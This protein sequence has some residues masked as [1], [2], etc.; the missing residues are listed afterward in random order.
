MFVAD[1][2]ELVQFGFA[3]VGPDQQYPIVVHGQDGT[4][5]DRVVRF[6]L[7][8][9]GR[10]NGNHFGLWAAKHKLQVGAQVAERFSDD[11]FGIVIYGQL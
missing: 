10:M 6:S 5:V 2:K 7:A 1:V 11:G 8:G 4:Q 9:I 3:H